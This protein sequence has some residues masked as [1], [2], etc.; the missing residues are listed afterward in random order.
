[1]RERG[2]F[3]SPAF[4]FAETHATFARSLAVRE[5]IIAD[6]WENPLLHLA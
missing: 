3:V 2:H 1:M 4:V 6:F 5:R